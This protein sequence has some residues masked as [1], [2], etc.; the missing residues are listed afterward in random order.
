MK[1]QKKLGEAEGRSDGEKID[2]GKRGGGGAWVVD[3]KQ[4]LLAFAPG[5]KSEVRYSLDVL[6]V[7]EEIRCVS[8]KRM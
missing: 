5:R 1:E 6:T 7:R 2:A 3:L 8:Q 4:I